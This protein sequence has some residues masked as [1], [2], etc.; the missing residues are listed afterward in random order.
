MAASPLLAASAPWTSSCANRRPSASLRVPKIFAVAFA[1]GG[2]HALALVVARASEN[3]DAAGL[4]DDHVANAMAQFGHFLLF[5]AHVK[6]AD[7][8]ILLVV[9]RFVGRN[10]PIL[11]H[12]GPSQIRLAVQDRGNHEVRFAVGFGRRDVRSDG[13][14]CS[15]FSTLVHTRSMSP[16]SFIRWKIVHEPPTSDFTS[17][18]TGEGA[19]IDAFLPSH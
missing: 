18:T 19:A 5:H 2:N 6:Q 17:S 3:V 15:A 9:E 11:D 4:S 14:A 8:L 7:D 10:A 1:P 16:A 12:Q 13:R